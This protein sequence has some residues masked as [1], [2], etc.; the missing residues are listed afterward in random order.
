MERVALRAE[1]ARCR[2]CQRQAGQCRRVELQ[3]QDRAVRQNQQAGDRAG[4]PRRRQPDHH[5]QQ[6]HGWLGADGAQLQP[7]PRAG[8]F[9]T[10]DEGQGHDDQQDDQHRGPD[11]LSTRQARAGDPESQQGTQTGGGGLYH[12]RRARRAQTVLDHEPQADGNR[13]PQRCHPEGMATDH[14]PNRPV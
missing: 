3:G 10:K 6:D 5:R 11:G 12:H 14:L 1:G 2:P 8:Q 13:S 4:P 7:A 9:G